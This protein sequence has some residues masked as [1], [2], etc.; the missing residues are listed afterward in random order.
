MNRYGVGV[1][2]SSLDSFAVQVLATVGDGCGVG[3]SGVTDAGG[4][5]VEVTA[6]VFIEG[7]IKPKRMTTPKNKSAAQPHPP[8]F[9][10]SVFCGSS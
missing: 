6:G 2:K 7:D 4:V 3:T 8:L 5:G 10:G 1:L 9:V